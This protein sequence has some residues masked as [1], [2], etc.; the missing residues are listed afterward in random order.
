MDKILEIAQWLLV[1]YQTYVGLIVAVVSALIALFL[2]IPGAEPER[3]LQK[4]LDFLS[5]FSKKPAEPKE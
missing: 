3:S 5:K 4:A 1:N 2:L